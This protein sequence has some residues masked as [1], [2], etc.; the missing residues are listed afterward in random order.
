MAVLNDQTL[1]IAIANSPSLV[2]GVRPQDF[3]LWNSAI[4]PAS[5][6]LT[7]GEI[8]VPPSVEDADAYP[9]SPIGEYMLEQGQTAMVRTAE[10]V[11]LPNNIAA[12][13]FP[14]AHVSLSGLLMT[15]PGHVDPGYKGNLTFTVINFGKKAYQLRKGR[16]LCTLV[17][18]RMEET[19]KYSYDKLD[20]TSRP[21]NYADLNDVL[22]R[23][24]HE[25]MDFTSKAKKEAEKVELAVRYRQVTYPLI[26]TLIAGVLTALGVYFF[27]PLR[28]ITERVTVLEARAGAQS[29][30]DAVKQFEQRLQLLE[31][32]LR[33]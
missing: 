18:F 29:T 21:K 28:N 32:Q 2:S 5:V 16:I 24:S 26:A 20:T 19:P 13:G 22:R 7:V 10:E 33:R 9:V 1:A 25:F 11:C 3:G 6:D 30:L 17:F 15:N 12:I 8:L 14:P 31:Q 27:N 23:L 4:Q